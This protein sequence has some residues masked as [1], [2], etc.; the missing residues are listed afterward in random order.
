MS[1]QLLSSEILPEKE[2]KLNDSQEYYLININLSRVHIR[3]LNPGKILLA[4]NFSPIRFSVRFCPIPV[5]SSGGCNRRKNIIVLR[6]SR[7]K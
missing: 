2:R 7:L 4:N 1:K 6:P 3:K 5:T